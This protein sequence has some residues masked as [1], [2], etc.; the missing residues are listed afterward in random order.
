MIAMETRPLAV[1]RPPAS[2]GCRALR[3]GLAAA[4]LAALVACGGSGVGSNGTGAAPQGS[5]AG[6]VTGFGSIY[7]DGVAYDDS[8]ARV[9]IEGTD[10]ALVLAEARVGQRVE[11]A[12][13]PDS[14]DP[15]SGERAQV[16]RIRIEPSLVGPVAAVQADGLTV[17]GQTVRVNTDP[18]RG[19]LTVVD[20]GTPGEDL[21][22]LRSGDLVEVHAYRL[23]VDGGEQLQAT[24]IEKLGQPSGLKVSGSVTAVEDGGLRIGALRV[25]VPAG[26]PVSPV[27]SAPAV[28]QW[29]RVHAAAGAWDEATQTLTAARL[30]VGER[31]GEWSAEDRV[32]VGGPVTRLQREAGVTRLQVDGVWVRVLAA[33][34]LEPADAELGLG[35]YLRAEGVQSAD[36]ELLA[37]EIHVHSVQDVTRVSGTVVDLNDDGNVFRVRDTWVHVEPEATVDFGAC[38]AAALADD[39]YVEVA[40]A[41]RRGVL[42]AASVVCRADADDQEPVRDRVI[43]RH[44]VVGTVDA[45]ARRF[46]LRHRDNEVYTVRWN[47]STYFRAPLSA[48]QP[49]ALP[50]QSVEVEGLW[51]DGVLLARKIRLRESR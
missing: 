16:R 14:F 4:W 34:R 30:R 22:A 24:R 40:G 28:G 6:T 19:P 32:S 9:E 43:E 21:E 11:L 5:S 18:A 33:T 25:R 37:E 13:D 47:D 46:T 27:G 2:G 48:Q 7:V 12:F 29:L 39:Q 45:A 44:G 23:A 35:L 15:D 42:V 10:G 38:T 41:M 50:E 3:A 31:S 51:Q 26:T 36:G 8:Q 49:Q 1:S 20:T 17:L